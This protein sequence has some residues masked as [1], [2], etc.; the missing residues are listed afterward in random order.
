M[1]RLRLALAT[2]LT[3]LVLPAPFSQASTYSQVLAAYQ[4]NGS[5][6]PCKFSSAQLSSAMRAIST[7]GAQYFADFT[8]AIQT[9]LDAR[10]AGQC[11]AAASARAGGA[12]AAATAPSALG[13]AIRLGPV[14]AATNASIPLPLLAL[15]VLTAVL[16]M[17]LALGAAAR[18]RGW[19]PAWAVASRHSWQEAGY[20]VGGLWAEFV[21]WLRS[22]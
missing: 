12:S 17:I 15:A 19:A 21:D 5:I 18:R 6:P 3:V 9:A 11:T 4:A 8:N 10:A 2:L 7:Y 13:P 22:D 14:T 16:A 20:R 1:S